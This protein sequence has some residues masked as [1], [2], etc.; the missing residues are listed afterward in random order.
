MN[1]QLN[2]KVY[3]AI[4]QE[5]MGLVEGS[6]EGKRL[7]ELRSTLTDAV[8]E[9]MGFDSTRELDDLVGGLIVLY[10]E[11]MFKYGLEIGRNPMAA[12]TLPDSGFDL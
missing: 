6:D 2:T 9:K 3:E 1:S 5:C 7:F 4:E 12:L 11:E 10:G 8:K